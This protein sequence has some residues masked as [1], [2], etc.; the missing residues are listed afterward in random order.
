MTQFPF[1]DILKVTSSFSGSSTQ[2]AYTATY[3]ALVVATPVTFNQADALYVTGAGSINQILIGGTS[4]SIATLGSDPSL[5]KHTGCCVL[6]IGDV[7]NHYGSS[8]STSVI[9]Y[10]LRLPELWLS[11]KTIMIKLFFVAFTLYW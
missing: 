3:R 6:E 5:N 4:E 7:V 2:T 11:S 9:L 10:I 1:L 8:S